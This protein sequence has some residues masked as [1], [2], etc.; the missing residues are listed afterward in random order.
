MDK[1]NFFL[2]QTYASSM[3]SVKRLQRCHLI[4]INNHS[5]RPVRFVGNNFSSQHIL[6]GYKE[7]IHAHQ[8]PLTYDEF[9]R[10]VV[11]PL[12]NFIQYSSTIG[13]GP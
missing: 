4:I 13:E 5:N 12:L 6:F 9:G 11:R 10:T 7:T 3:M 2:L 1:E 8:Q